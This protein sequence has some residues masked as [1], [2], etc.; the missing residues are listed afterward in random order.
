MA[1]IR[2]GENER[3]PGRGAAGGVKPMTAE[4][5]V[6]WCGQCDRKRVVAVSNLRPPCFRNIEEQADCPEILERRASGD[7]TLLTMMCGALA[8]SFAENLERAAV[9]VVDRKGVWQVACRIPGD[10]DRYYSSVQAR[11][12][13]EIWRRCGGTGLAKR[14]RD[15][16]K[17]A[18]RASRSRQRMRRLVPILQFG[19]VVA[20]V[21]V[22]WFLLSRSTPQPTEVAAQTPAAE[23]QSVAVAD[24]APSPASAP[25]LLAAEPLSPQPAAL[26]AV[27]S[28]TPVASPTSEAMPQA[29]STEQASSTE[30]A[31]STEQAISTEQAPSSPDAKTLAS[32]APAANDAASTSQAAPTPEPLAEPEMVSIPG[33]TFVMGS[34][35]NPSEAPSHSVSIK[36]FA[37]SKAVVTVRAWS[38]CVAAKACPVVEIDE[39][40]DA[41]VTNVSFNDAQRFIA[42][43]CEA[44]HTNFRLPTEA[45]WEYAARG[46]T[47]SKYWW[48]DDIQP[49]MINCKGCNGDQ[50]ARQTVRAEDFKPNPFGL[51]DMGGNVAQWVSDCWHKNYQGAVADGSAWVDSGYCVFHV[52]RSGS[53]RS[54]ATDVR[55]AS[56]DFYDGRIRYPTHGFRVA[57]SL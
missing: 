22:A 8:G 20:A 48:G 40:D 2:N 13:G 28:P 50:N 54:A 17:Q 9:D 56:R 35:L 23:Q 19:V 42:W 53:W 1:D 52:I 7:E 21:G 38:Q 6:V 16:A 3:D 55:P 34:N 36:P 11:R 49:G 44:A 10:R 45:E 43:L 27:A 26:E 33:G 51:H 18:D 47:H 5:H 57:R 15:A 30:Q 12:Q 24:I 37:I 4:S 32:A 41:P 46:G 31:P 29:P 39:N 14:F 25:R